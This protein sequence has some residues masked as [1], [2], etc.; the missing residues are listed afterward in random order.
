[1]AKEILEKTNEISDGNIKDVI[2]NERPLNLSNLF[3][4]NENTSIADNDTRFLEARLNLEEVRLKMTYEANKALLDSD[5]KIDTAP[6]EDLIKNL[7]SLITNGSVDDK[8]QIIEMT[9]SRV[10]TISKGPAAV[11]GQM[12]GKFNIAT[13]TDIS[14][15][16]TLMASRYKKAGEAYEPLMT[17]PRAD[18]GDSIKKAFG[19]IDEILEE[20]QEEVNDDNRR[21]VRILGYNRLEINKKSVEEV[22]GWDQLLR[23][24]IDRIKPGAILDLIKEGKN[25]L[26]MTLEELSYNLDQSLF[27]GQD[28]EKNGNDKSKEKYSRFLYKLEK[29]GDITEKEKQSFI[30]IYR[31]FHNLKKDDYKAIGS[32]LKTGQEMTLKNLLDATRIQKRS[33]SKMD[34]T[35]DDDF[36]GLGTKG[37]KNGLK[38]DEQINLAFRFYS[39]KAD[40]VYENLEPEKLQIVQPNENT[41]LPDLANDL[42]NAKTDEQITRDYYRQQAEEVRQTLSG[43]EAK[44]ALDEILERDRDRRSGSIWQK[45]V[46]VSEKEAL[47][48]QQ[49]LVDA[50]LDDDYVKTYQKSLERMSEKLSDVL[51]NEDDTYIDVRSINLMQKQL[52]V[53]SQSSEKGSFE[54]PVEVDGQKISMHITLLSEEGM[55]S[56]MEASV[57]TYEYGLVTASLYVQDGIVNGMLTTTNANSSEESE[58]LEGVRT[59]LCDKM[60]EKLKD[61]GIN[62]ER[63]AI[64][65]HAQTRPASPGRVNANATDG[66]L[67]ENTDTK[68]FLTMAKAFIEAL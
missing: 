38:I 45:T 55:N 34:Y 53:M 2:A 17:A 9:M 64:L 59:K 50:L 41:L 31:L 23:S 19:N 20:I 49:L 37:D 61:L 54:V 12:L 14:A 57:Q 15:S 4:A 43:R 42:Q 11:V 33:Q 40:I 7:Q 29:K 58:Y 18:L 30:G 35:V 48:E 13:L 51:M 5:F 65:Y 39:A 62:Q 16:S 3:G 26:K 8:S 47:T 60:A 10:E 1:M 46:D 66:N 28:G 36:G 52:S 21:A 22:K 25:P 67:K 44:G 63:I 56:R 68:V 24:T 27:N 6:I 32:V